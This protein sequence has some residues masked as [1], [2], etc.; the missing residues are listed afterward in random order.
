MLKTDISYTKQLG[1]LKPND[2]FNSLCLCG[3]T[4]TT[5]HGKLFMKNK[6]KTLKYKLCAACFRSKKKGGRSAF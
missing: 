5:G 1:N 6:K 2:T 4:I 3:M